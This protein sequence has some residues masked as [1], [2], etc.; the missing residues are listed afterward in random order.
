MIS[1]NVF[2]K[3]LY[4]AAIISLYLSPI[5][6]VSWLLCKDR[7]SHNVFCMGVKGNVSSIAGQGCFLEKDCEVIVIG[8]HRINTNHQIDWSMSILNEI[9]KDK[10]HARGSHV[11]FYITKT[12]AY[13]QEDGY[14]TDTVYI[15]AYDRRH[16]GLNTTACSKIDSINVDT[17]CLT[18]KA[19]RIFVGF[20][21]KKDE[22]SASKNVY[23]EFNFMSSTTGMI[24]YHGLD[25]RVRLFE[26]TLYPYIVRKK[27][28]MSRNTLS[29]PFKETESHIESFGQLTD[30]IDMFN[31]IGIPTTTRPPAIKT[32]SISNQ[33]ISSSAE[34]TKD[35]T[36]ESANHSSKQTGRKGS[37]QAYSYLIP[38]GLSFCF[39]VLIT[40][41]YLVVT[42][43]KRSK[44]SLETGT[45]P[46]NQPKTRNK[47]K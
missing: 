42:W 32:T 33:P 31:R 8:F 39:M 22:D 47:R 17:N 40:I 43:P 16:S 2:S 19:G 20:K 28:D 11:F 5:H 45:N 38:I 37:S 4:I 18:T 1:L 41:V 25:Y 30:P 15:D 29:E 12:P 7:S 46:K 21:H 44:Q 34:P 23:T 24:G 35:A 14:P 3:V 13:I 6:T 27:L 9:I 10:R 26:E 36:T